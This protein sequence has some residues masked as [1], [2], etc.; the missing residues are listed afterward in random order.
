RLDGFRGRLLFEDLDHG[1]LLRSISVMPCAILHHPGEKLDPVAA[2]SVPAGSSARPEVPALRARERTAT[3]QM[4]KIQYLSGPS[5]RI[6]SAFNRSAPPPPVRRAS[7]SAAIP[8][9]ADGP[10]PRTIRRRTHR[11]E[12][13]RRRW[14]SPR[15]CS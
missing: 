2:G 10:V 6:V 3:L 14:P 12:R 5:L 4:K 9:F 8:A 13:Q 15:R 7:A 1:Q 11:W